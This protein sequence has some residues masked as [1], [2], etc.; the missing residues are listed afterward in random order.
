MQSQDFAEMLAKAWWC[1]WEVIRDHAVEQHTGSCLKTW[2]QTHRRITLEVITRTCF[3]AWD[4]WQCSVPQKSLSLI[5]QWG[6]FFP[7]YSVLMGKNKMLIVYNFCVSL[8]QRENE[9]KKKLRIHC[10]ISCLYNRC[11]S[12]DVYVLYLKKSSF[13]SF[14]NKTNVWKKIAFCVC[15][16]LSQL[17][18]TIVF[19]YLHKCFNS[20]N[21]LWNSIFIW[22][23]YYFRNLI[24][25]TTAI[26]INSQ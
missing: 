7:F 25:S 21:F 5:V 10:N 26:A 12:N 8:I 18:P 14:T 1:N 11:G 19:L 4:L 9:E 17:H 16:L 23:N 2:T 6:W 24:I 15:L 20:K 22:Y 3:Y 13:L